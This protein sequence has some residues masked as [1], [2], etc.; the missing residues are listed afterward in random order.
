VR[1]VRG[2]PN[3]EKRAVK[4]LLAV[5]GSE[6]SNTAVETVAARPWAAGS[7]VRVLSVLHLPFTPTPETWSLPDSFYFELE[8]KGR[9]TLEAAVTRAA[10]RLEGSNSE[11]T[12]PLPLSSVVIL[13]H[14]EEEIIRE[15]KKWGADLIVLGSHGLSGWKR[16]M[17]GSVSH[18]V[19]S[20]A[21]CSVEIVR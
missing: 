21:P 18:A 8:K 4:I 6:C 9:E 3:P 13:G 15:A 11:R 1:V 10:E 12:D 19:A 7:E 20:H 16:F 5:D 17:L 14:P 2:A